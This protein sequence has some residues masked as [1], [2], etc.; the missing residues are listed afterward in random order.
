MAR[1]PDREQGVEAF[2]EIESLVERAARWVAGQPVPVMIALGILL[3]GT[4]VVAA[5]RWWNERGEQQGSAAVA[6]ARDG[7]L[8]A[9]G[10][11]PGAVTFAEPA[12]ADT[13]RKAREES[14]A[15]F[16][17]AAAAH[18]G[19][20]AA[21]EGWI[22]AGNLR[23]ALGER[24]AALE[25]WQRAVDEAPAHSAL[26]GLALE[27]LARG[28]EA[29]GDFA[30]A[31]AA[32]EEASAILDFPLRYHAMADAARSYALADQRDRAVALAERLDAEAPELRLPDHLKSRLAELRAR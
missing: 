31:A 28:R 16:A 14:A 25:A 23:E 17:E 7:F 30:G 27:R 10:A 19:T 15:R 6:E 4:A 3:S 1:R 12:N 18:A 8:R 11:E 26:R 20:A 13:A 22:E 24:D 9:M 5:A 29:K 21:V 2:E 32:F